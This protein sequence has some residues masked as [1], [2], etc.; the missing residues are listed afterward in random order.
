MLGVIP[1]IENLGIDDEDSV[2]LEET[3]LQAEMP[4]YL[5]QLF[6]YREFLI[7]L[8]LIA[9]L[10]KLIRM[11]IMYRHARSWGIQMPLS[12]REAKTR[13]KTCSG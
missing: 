8:I 4:I 7:L 1:Y 3:R 12:F 5:L 11:F 9:L 2:S 6:R 13:R 10:E